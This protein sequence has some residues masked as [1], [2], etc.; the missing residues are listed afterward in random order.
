MR[1]PLCLYNV[2][3][4]LRGQKTSILIPGP[5]V[6]T[7]S[8]YCSIMMSFP[9]SVSGDQSILDM[10]NRFIAAALIQAYL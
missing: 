10:D 2:C 8:F 5:S 4:E 6:L 3:V 1:C 9:L 7:G